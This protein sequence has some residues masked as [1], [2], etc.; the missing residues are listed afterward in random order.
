[1]YDKGN[2][3]NT[4]R[5]SPFVKIPE[6]YFSISSM[7]NKS[8]DDF[9][10]LSAPWSL[11]N[12]DLK[13]WDVFPEWHMIGVSPIIQYFNAPVVQM[14]SF[15]AFGDWNYG[16]V[17]NK[18]TSKDSVWILPFAGLL[19]AKYLLFHKDIE[20]KYLDQTISKMVYYSKNGFIDEI[21][22][23]E[24]LIFY[25]I[26][27]K[28]TIPHIYV[29]DNIIYLNSFKDM[30]EWLLQKRKDAAI[31]FVLNKSIHVENKLSIY[32]NDRK[33]VIEYK[34]ISGSKY[35]VKIHRATGTFPLVLSETY[36]PLWKIYLEN[37]RQDT[38]EHMDITNKVMIKQNNV[39][40]KSELRRLLQKDIISEIG[41]EKEKIRTRKIWRSL[42]DSYEY[43][44]QFDI[45]FISRLSKG[46]VQ[47]NNLS[48]GGLSSDLFAPEIDI[49]HVVANGYSNIWVVELEKI[50]NAYRD[51]VKQNS[52]GSYDFNVIIEFYPQKLL[53]IGRIFT[54]FFCFCS[55]CAFIIFMKKNP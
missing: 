36:N 19:N 38:P 8:D 11:F 42:A 55:L 51:Y 27:K 17:W 34:K 31:A 10:I 35:I 25:A 12:P 49:D 26:N 45:D 3:F 39:I 23:D 53:L 15:S 24:S 44:Y 22:S 5:F 7:I 50:K 28:Y 37:F 29:P 16:Q 32:D 18:E 46:T 48:D 21:Y 33:P 1:M 41:S 9:K 43:R 13:G 40:E 30:P 52:D 4:S 47:N 2:D 6:G 54:A 14:N 20:K